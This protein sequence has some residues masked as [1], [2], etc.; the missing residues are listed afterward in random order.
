MMVPPPVPQTQSPIRLTGRILLA[1]DGLDNQRL[2]STHLRKAGAEVVIAANGRVAVDL[3]REQTFDLILMDMQMPQLDGYGATSE[4][5]RRGFTLPIVALTA[6]AMADDRAKCIRAGCTDYLTKPIDK[7]LLLGTIRDYL[8]MT[9]AG[10][11]APAPAAEGAP[12]LGTRTADPAPAPAGAPRAPTTA[13][14]TTVTSFPGGPEH[15]QSEF[16][17]DP[18][19]KEVLGEFISG[20]PAQVAQIQQLLEEQNL[21]ELRRAVHQL[22]G[23]GGG[24][25]FPQITRLALSAEEEVKS[26]RALGSVRERVDALIALVRRVEG[27]DLRAEVAPTGQPT[28]QP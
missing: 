27:Y 28:G 24:Y 1:E 4:L 13:P 6:H 26:G 20:L 21:A 3:M 12:A 2:I 18:D 15:L 7:A 9:N 19:M 11:S 22:K 14:A 17:S 16:A 23:A 8:K 25:G 5:R 10:Q